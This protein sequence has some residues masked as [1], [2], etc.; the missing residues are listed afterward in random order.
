M[1]TKIHAVVDGLGNP[2]RI[3]LTGGNTNDI[4]PACDLIAGL[5]ADKTI[6]DRA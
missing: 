5:Q 2:I 3:L 1:T 4:V 6:A